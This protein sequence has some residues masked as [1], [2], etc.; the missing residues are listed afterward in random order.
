MGARRRHVEW[1]ALPPKTQEKLLFL[2]VSLSEFRAGYSLWVRQIIA[3]GILDPSATFLFGAINASLHA[4][5]ID[6]PTDIGALPVI[7][8]I[9]RDDLAMSIKKLLDRK[10]GDKTVRKRISDYR[11]RFV[12]HLLFTGEGFQ[13]GMSLSDNADHKTAADSVRYLCRKTVKLHGWIR[14]T[15]PETDALIRHIAKVGVDNFPPQKA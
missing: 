7:R 4:F 9:G 3:T 15:Y 13:E 10:A 8:A 5:Y 12:A 1:D 6:R 11:H 14:D 2:T